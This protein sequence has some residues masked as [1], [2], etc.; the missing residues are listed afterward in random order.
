MAT[1]HVTVDLD[2]LERV[3]ETHINETEHDRG[4]DIALGAVVEIAKEAGALQKNI[5]ALLKIIGDA[6]LCRGCGAEIWWVVNP[7]TSKR[8]PITKAGLSHFADCPNA[9]SFRKA[10]TK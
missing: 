10:K 3:L 9:A 1:N 8:M 5:L 7:K 6:D 2:H 4:I